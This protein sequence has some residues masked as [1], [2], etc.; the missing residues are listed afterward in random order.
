MDRVA[1]AATAAAAG[2]F[3]AGPV[4]RLVKKKTSSV[5]V[6]YVSCV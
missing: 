5:E 4:L 3:L 6:V 1:I 2:Y